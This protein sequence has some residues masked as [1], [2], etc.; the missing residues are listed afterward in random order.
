LSS[1]GKIVWLASYPKSGNTW[2]RVLLNGLMVDSSRASSLDI[3]ALD[4]TDHAGSRWLVEAVSACP[5]SELS[6]EEVEQLRP[7]GFRALCSRKAGPIV[8]K[9]HDAYRLLAP[10]RH[11]FPA[12]ISL[13]AIYIVRNPFDVAV[14]LAA[15]L[16]IDIDDVIALMGKN[17]TLA[18]YP[19]S[20][21]PQV[22]QH[23]GSWSAHVDSW[24]LQDAIPL[25]VVRYEDL[26][27]RTSAVL[28]RAAR[29]A[30][31]SATRLELVQAVE[32]A[33]FSRLQAMEVKAGFREKSNRHDGLF[34]RSG[35]VGDWRAVLSQEQVDRLVKGHERIMNKFGY[36]DELQ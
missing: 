34:F 35:R 15:H 29:A 1:A 28:E 36:L 7:E 16:G 14:S 22:R 9:V 23:L 18:D 10:S 17:F 4:L 13:G 3:N 26:V 33:S 5:S 24:I 19:S 25:E 11:L 12:D 20:V 27:A 32:A 8:V 6:P 21:A 2:M 31:L 30:G